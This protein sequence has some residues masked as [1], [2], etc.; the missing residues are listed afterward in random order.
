MLN[1]SEFLF[2]PVIAARFAFM[3]G[4]RQSYVVIGVAFREKGAL[5]CG[6]QAQGI[7]A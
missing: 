6:L 1:L 2:H 4:L 5:F 3:A 7:G